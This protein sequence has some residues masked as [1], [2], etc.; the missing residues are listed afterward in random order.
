MDLRPSSAHIWTQCAAQPRMAAMVPPEVPTDPAREGTCAAWVAEL[1]LTGAVAQCTDLVGQSHEN[2]WLVEIDM[3]RRIQKYVDLVRSYGGEIHVERK[4]RLNKNIAGTPDSYAVLT[5]DKVLRVDD[6]KYGFGVVEPVRNPQISVYAGAVMRQLLARGVVI[7]RVVIGVYQPR[8]YHP[9][10]IH[11]TWSTYPENL[12]AFV[13][14]IETAG[15]RAQDPNATPTA[16]DHCEYCPAAATCPVVAH[17]NYRVYDALT[18]DRQRHMNAQELVEELE[19]LRVASDMLKGRSSA[20]H[21][22]AEARIQKGEHL[23]GWHMEQRAGQRRFKFPAD[24][25]RAMTNVNPVVH[26]MVTPAELER[27]GADEKV[28]AALSE[29]PRT[30]PALKKIA[31]GYFTNLFK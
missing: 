30:K 2:G 19:F 8:A 27:L 9:A 20:V 22:E 3:A 21:A 29:T 16:G 31:P 4:V 12:M 26:K 17:A 7:Q 11:R 13:H 23:P 1:T 24:V 18:N 10:G 5:A 14:E 6:L 28:V 25:V 15:E